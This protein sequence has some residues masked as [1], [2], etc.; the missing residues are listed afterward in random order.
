M[1]GIAIYTLGFQAL[2][3]IILSM[4]IPLNISLWVFI[5]SP[6]ISFT[7]EALLVVNPF[8]SYLIQKDACELLE[9]KWGM[10]INN[11]KAPIYPWVPLQPAPKRQ[12]RFF[13]YSQDVNQLGN[14]RFGVP[15]G[16][17]VLG[18]KENNENSAAK[19][20]VKEQIIF[21]NIFLALLSCLSFVLGLLFF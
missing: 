5:V 3:P 12:S 2:I 18:L 17:L 19:L 1:S 11:E 20:Q 10:A 13:R 16:Y 6:R 8:K 9:T 4:F 14:E 15:E 7:D 21:T